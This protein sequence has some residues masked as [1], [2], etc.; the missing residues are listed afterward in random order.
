M[1]FSASIAQKRLDEKTTNPFNQPEKE[2]MV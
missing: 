1:F 2:L